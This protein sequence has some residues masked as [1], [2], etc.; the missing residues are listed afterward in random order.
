MANSN[1]VQSLVRG[2]DIFA[3]LAESPESLS[4][5]A[6]A[7]HMGLKNTTAHN[8][9]RTLRE[10]GFVAQVADSQEYT[11]GPRLAE[12]AA[13]QHNSVLL[14]RVQS[15]LTKLAK[16]LSE[17]TLTFSQPSGSEVRVRL[18]MSPDRPGQIQHPDDSILGLY[19]SASGLT[20]L[21][22]A[23]DETLVPLYQ[24][25]P[26]LEEGTAYWPSPAKLEACLDECR[27]SG[28]ALHPLRDRQHYAVAVPVRNQTGSFIG[29]LGASQRA[30]MDES[31]TESDHRSMGERLIAFLQNHQ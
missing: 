29:I 25:H 20:T 31:F 17:A 8:L 11:A 2:L 12:L 18:R 7:H 19:S 1:L 27:R 4:L 10:R 13:R 22:F 6:I 14:S 28:Y 21:A 23:D 3:L 15:F 30:R 24:R 16:E 26:F 9:L 5:K